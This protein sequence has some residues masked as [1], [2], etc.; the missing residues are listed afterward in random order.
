MYLCRIRVEISN[1]AEAI[2]NFACA[3]TENFCPLP[4]KRKASSLTTISAGNTDSECSEELVEVNGAGAVAV[5]A[6]EGL[7]DT[8]VVEVEAHLLDGFAELRLRDA[9]TPVVI[10]DLELSAETTVYILTVSLGT[11]VHPDPRTPCTQRTR[12]ER[13]RRGREVR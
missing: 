11:F 2:L 12:L 8:V 9:P 5:K 4:K 3:P 7:V 13:V 1:F 10:D 6:L